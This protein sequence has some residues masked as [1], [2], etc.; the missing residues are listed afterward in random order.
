MDE[1]ELHQAIRNDPDDEAPRLALA[2]WLNAHG[3][4]D[5][6]EWI[7]AGFEVAR[8]SFQDERWAPLMARIRDTFARCRPV[9]WETLTNVE[10]K[11]DRGMFRFIVGQSRSSR[12]PAPVKRLGQVTWLSEAMSD[13]WL[14]RIEVLWSDTAVAELLS[15]WKGP[16]ARTP[17]LVR[18]APQIDDSGLERILGLPQLQGLMLQ[19]HVL[20]NP[21]AQSLD[22]C[23]GLRDLTV[24]FRL[25]EAATVDAMLDRIAASA[26]LRRLHL[27]GHDRVGYG[28]RPNDADLLRLRGLA[29]LKRLYLSDTPAVTDKGIE[30]LRR[31]CPS[32]I[33]ARL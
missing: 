18:P 10:Q 27:S 33:V 20:R 19:A 9:W 21:S 12:G 31:L 8:I 14:Q 25:V 32:L 17:L 24:E 2:D 15:K 22:Q 6:A 29:R 7:R 5:R 11:N 1:K 16:A 28:D 3:Q 26:D 23:A 30:E 4:T 13:G